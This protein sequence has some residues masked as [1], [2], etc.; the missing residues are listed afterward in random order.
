LAPTSFQ[1]YIRQTGLQGLNCAPVEPNIAI[2]AKPQATRIKGQ[3]AIKH[4][5]KTKLQQPIWQILA[6]GYTVWLIHYRRNGEEQGIGPALY[7]QL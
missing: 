2:F 5:Y 3:Y 1:Q 6:S 7:Q 4:K